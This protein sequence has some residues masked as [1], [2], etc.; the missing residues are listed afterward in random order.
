M[1]RKIFI[2]L[3]I[4]VAVM[5][6]C[7]C[8]YLYERPYDA[9][10]DEHYEQPREG[11]YEQPREDHYE[12]PREEPREEPPEEPREEPP[13]EPREQPPEEP[14]AGIGQQVYVE[15]TVQSISNDIVNI[16]TQQGESYILRFSEDVKWAPDVEDWHLELGKYIAVTML[17]ETPGQGKVMQVT[18][19]GFAG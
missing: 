2:G 17:I 14:K 7:G 9:P 10:R 8:G 5:A 1:S 13:E 16:I 11:H 19:N 3:I 18:F 12:E 4:V 6:L 15:G